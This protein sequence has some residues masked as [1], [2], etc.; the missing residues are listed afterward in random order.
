MHVRRGDFKSFAQHVVLSND[1]II[2]N[3]KHH[4]QKETLFLITDEYDDNLISRLKEICKQVICLSDI[5]NNIIYDMLLCAA[6]KKFIGTPYSSFS[7]QITRFR[8]SI[9]SK[10]ETF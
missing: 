3:N 10:V 6:A 9:Y 5:N 8:K 4:F 2:E 7:R 1:E